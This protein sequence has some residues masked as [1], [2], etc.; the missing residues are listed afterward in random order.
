M[1][2][3][4]S[5][6]LCSAF[7]SPWAFAFTVA[8]AHKVLLSGLGNCICTWILEQKGVKCKHADTGYWVLLPWSGLS[9]VPEM[10]GW[11]VVLWCW[12]CFCSECQSCVAWILWLYSSLTISFGH[13]HHMPHLWASAD[14]D[15][16]HAESGNSSFVLLCFILNSV[17][18]PERMHCVPLENILTV[19]TGT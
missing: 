3:F 4:S 9:K 2:T 5:N 6:G 18:W 8:I 14:V 13:L 16:L 1:K 15:L 19:I 12:V 7:G 10:D 17:W 11:K